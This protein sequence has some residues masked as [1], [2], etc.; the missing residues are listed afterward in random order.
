MSCYSITGL[1]WGAA[2]QKVPQ[3]AW[4]PLMIGILLSVH[5]AS[6]LPLILTFLFQDEP[7]AVL[8]MG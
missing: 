4:V 6:H 8:D 7:Y 2:L 1:F 5:S 3:G